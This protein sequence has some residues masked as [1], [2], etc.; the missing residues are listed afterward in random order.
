MFIKKNETTML[1]LA[2]ILLGLLLSLMTA[3]ASNEEATPT[4][5][6]DLSLL[7]ELPTIESNVEEVVPF[8][9]AAPAPTAPTAPTALDPASINGTLWKDYCVLLADGSPSG[10]CIAN[11]NGGYRADGLFNNNEEGIIAVKVDLGAGPCPANDIILSTQTDETGYYG[12]TIEDASPEGGSYCVSIDPLAEVNVNILVPGD[13]TYPAAGVGSVTVRAGEKNSVDFGWDPQQDTAPVEVVEEVEDCENK[14]AYVSDVTIPDNT[15][16]SPN[17]TFVKTWRVRNE[18]TCS[19]G[20][21]YALTFAAGA[22]LGG[23][24]SVPFPQ[25]VAPGETVDLSVTLTAPSTGGS[26][27]SEWQFQDGSGNTFGSLGDYPLY[28]TIVV[29]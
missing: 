9:T 15:I 29:P 26:Y 19:W 21:G 28:T 8:E 1:L 10:G 11:G 3:C 22:Q 13:W 25:V 17:E 12:F 16:L 6:A 5:E 4:E 23:A 24:A 18:G 2:I 7:E 27:R 14:A 20:P